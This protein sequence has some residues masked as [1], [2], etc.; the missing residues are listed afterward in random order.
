MN[1][2]KES[3][4]T[5]DEVVQK[6]IIHLEN[7]GWIIDS[8]CLGHTHGCDIVATKNKIELVIEVKGAR[9]SDNSPVKKRDFFDSGQIKTHFGKS[10]VKVLEE[11]HKRPNSTFG[12]A[13]PDDA[14]IRKAIG[15]LVSNLKKLNIIH[16]WVKIN[17]EIVEE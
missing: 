3:K 2:D 14:D 5:E 12:I 17:G 16:Y 1:V 8:F 15:H 11:M 7:N 13:H 9:A 10:M 4:Q 6:L